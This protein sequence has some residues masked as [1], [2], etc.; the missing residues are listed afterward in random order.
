MYL[1][2]VFNVHTHI[3]VG[4]LVGADQVSMEAWEAYY[5]PDREETDHHF[6]HSDT[7]KSRNKQFL[8]REKYNHVKAHAEWEKT[9]ITDLQRAS[10]GTKLYEHLTASILTYSLRTVVLLPIVPCYQFIWL[11]L[12]NT[13][14]FYALTKALRSQIRHECFCL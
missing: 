14:I 6:Q 7:V 4:G 13:V 12:Q 5:R 10:M 9:H 1:A 3:F 2:G 11:Q 8:F